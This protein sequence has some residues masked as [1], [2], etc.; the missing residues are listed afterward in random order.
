M[1]LETNSS[2]GHVRE[3]SLLLQEGTVSKDALVKIAQTFRS[4]T[5]D[6]DA[7][8]FVHIYLNDKTQQSPDTINDIYVLANFRPVVTNR[9]WRMDCGVAGYDNRLGLPLCFPT[10]LR[11]EDYIYRLWIQQ[12]GIVAAHVDAA[13]NHTKSN[14]MR[15]PLASEIFNEEISNLLKRKIKDSIT[16]LDDLAIEFGYEGEVTLQDSE[17]ILDRII[18]LHG[19]VV[20]AASVTHDAARRQALGLFAED[21]STAFYSFEPDFFQ[22]NVTRIVGEEVSQFHASLKLWPTLI[23]ICYFRKDKRDLPQTRVRNQRK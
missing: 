8:D 2:K 19:Q 21:L 11:F 1:D 15:D 12:K 10:R 17:E 3:N 5:S 6:I 22:Q 14:Y 7:I 18:M 9:N 4:G 20:A 23:E 13:Q 16:R